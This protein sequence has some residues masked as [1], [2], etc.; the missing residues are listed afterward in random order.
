MRISLLFVVLLCSVVVGCNNASNKANVDSNGISDDQKNITSKDIEALEFDDYAL[1]DDAEQ[2]IENWQKYHE[3]DE[4]IGYLHTTDFSFFSGEKEV[5]KA[6]INDFKTE[7]PE[8]IKTASILARLTVLETMLLKLNSLLR[9]DNVD[10]VTRLNAIKEVLVSMSNMN[11][12]INKK[13]E[14]DANLVEKD[15][16]IEDQS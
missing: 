13:F 4:Q 3:L 2:A 1:S 10:K 8:S 11:L 5:L 7:M 6:F 16:T 15:N 14:L 12:Q 9:L